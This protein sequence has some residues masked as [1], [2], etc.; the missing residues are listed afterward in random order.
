MRLGT[1][2]LADV[3]ERLPAEARGDQVSF[4]DPYTAMVSLCEHARDAWER[5]IAR[6]LFV[7][8]SAQEQA[9]VLGEANVPADR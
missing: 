4:A 3:A 1:S 6:G 8:V 7:R 9:G 5:K 2:R